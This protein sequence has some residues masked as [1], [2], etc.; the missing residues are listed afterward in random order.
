MATGSRRKYSELTADRRFEYSIEPNPNRL[1]SVTTP[2]RFSDADA[3]PHAAVTREGLF[4]TTDASLPTFRRRLTSHPAKHDYSV[5]NGW[6]IDAIGTVVEPVADSL[7]RQPSSRSVWKPEAD[8][9]NISDGL[10]TEDSLLG[11]SWDMTIGGKSTVDGDEDRSFERIHCDVK[12]IEPRDVIVQSTR[13]TEFDGD[14]RLAW[15]LSSLERSLVAHCLTVKK[16]ARRDRRNDNAEVSV[17]REGRSKIGARRAWKRGAAARYGGIDLQ[18][19]PSNE[20]F[21]AD[22]VG[23]ASCMKRMMF[24]L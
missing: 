4:P 19:G 23:L 21:R 13:A 7:R 22:K 17:C 20:P 3:V 14:V 9:N 12:E 1:P 24:K 11:Q 18:P 15:K 6:R 10:R 8:D 16:R 2:R 5:T